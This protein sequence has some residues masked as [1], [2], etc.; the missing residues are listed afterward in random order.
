MKKIEDGPAM[1]GMRGG[2]SLSALI[3][4][5]IL[6][7]GLGISG[8]FIATRPKASP[9]ERERTAPIVEVME[10]APTSAKARI[11]AMGTVVAADEALIQAEVSGR[12]VWV[13]P[14][15]VDGGFVTKDT[16]VARIDDRDYRLA[17]EQQRSALQ[18]ALAELRLEE[19]R[20]NVAAFEWE[21]MNQKEEQGEGDLALR[22]PQLEAAE[23]AVRSARANVSKALLSL[24]RTEI[25]APFDAVISDAQADVGDQ[26]N[27]GAVLARLIAT[28]TFYVK[29]LV[30]TDQLKWLKFSGPDLAGGSTVLI[31]PVSGGERTG[32]LI[33]LAPE[34]SS[35]GRMAQLIV[36]VDDPLLLKPGDRT[37]GILLLDD[38]VRVQIIGTEMEGVLSIPRT[39][40]REGR[41]VWL[42][43][44]DNRLRIV[45]AEIVFST[46]DNVYVE[47]DFE[48]GSRLITSSLGAPVEGMALSAEGEDIPQE[49]SV[50]PQSELDR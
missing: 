19:G 29:C 17:L 16:V 1:A 43:D 27:P 21:F 8:W 24:D 20:Q 10:L 38:F 48:A 49:E 31:Y 4:V 35:S 39:A 9:R 22:K 11:E 46:P 34:L 28:N 50:G 3:A 12:I 30:R 25:S 42:L 15:M 36:S 14:E 26:A 6:V 18:S 45:S 37:R 5:L 40:L 23:A 33:N 32:R 47:N 13:H 7:L 44:K 2:K 41:S